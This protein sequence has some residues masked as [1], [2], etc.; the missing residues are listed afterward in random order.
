MTW[1]HHRS[2]P[3]L[4]GLLD[5]F[6]FLY[7]IAWPFVVRNLSNHLTVFV[8]LSFATEAHCSNHAYCKQWYCYAF[9]NSLPCSFNH[10]PAFGFL[11]L[12][13][14]T[15]AVKLMG[16]KDAKADA[17]VM[18]DVVDKVTKKLDDG[19]PSAPRSQSSYKTAPSGLRR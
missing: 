19:T 14:M 2:Y 17:A 9:P 5:F 11:F 13:V 15:T 8:W 3:K 4:E 1:V 10:E 12:Q 16:K 18:V 6:L 7:K